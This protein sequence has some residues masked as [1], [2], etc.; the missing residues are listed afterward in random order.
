MVYRNRP[1]KENNACSDGC[2]FHEENR[3]MGQRVS[4]VEDIHECTDTCGVCDPGQGRGISSSM[5]SID[6]GQSIYHGGQNHAHNCTLFLSSFCDVVSLSGEDR[7]GS[8]K[9]G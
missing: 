5:P 2:K 8:G 1:H 7:L 6:H 9:L 3:E 4:G